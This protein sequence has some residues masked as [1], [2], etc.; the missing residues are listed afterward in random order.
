MFPIFR[1][2][3]ARQEEARIIG[4]R[5]DDVSVAPDADPATQISSTSRGR[6]TSATRIPRRP[7]PSAAT[8]IGPARASTTVKRCAAGAATTR[9]R[10]PLFA[11]DFN[12]PPCLLQK[13]VWPLTVWVFLVSGYPQDTQ[14]HAESRASI[15]VYELSHSFV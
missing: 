5:G 9:S 8:A 11:D 2:S 6:R 13:L 12:V 14:R 15:D 7:G 1:R 10:Y 4:G 3:P